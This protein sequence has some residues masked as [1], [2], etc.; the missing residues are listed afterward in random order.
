MARSREHPHGKM[1][2]RCDHL[3]YHV[4]APDS[5]KW[6]PDVDEEL[7][8][9]I[10]CVADIMESYVPKRR[11]R[12]LTQTLKQVFDGGDEGDDDDWTLPHMFDLTTEEIENKREDWLKKTET[13]D[14]LTEEYGKLEKQ[15]KH[16]WECL[17]A[18]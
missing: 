15:Y 12:N 9:R 6:M 13:D 4:P 3:A 10:C 14:H 18:A 5:S 1:F 7:W 8:H 2:F 17:N 16:N 11:R